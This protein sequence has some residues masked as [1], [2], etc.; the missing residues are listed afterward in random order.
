MES[1]KNVV[2]E[3]HTNPCPSADDAAGGGHDLISG[4]S[5]DVLVRILGLVG[6]A[7]EV[8]RTGALSRRWRGLWAGAPA[9]YFDVGGFMSPGD[10]ERFIAVIDDVL[11]LRARSDSGIERVE[12]SFGVYHGCGEPRLAPSCVGAAE[13]WIRYAVQH[14]LTSFFF[15]VRVT[16]K[17]W[18]DGFDKEDEDVGEDYDGDGDEEDGEE[19]KV[20]VDEEENDGGS[21][22]DNHSS[23]IDNDKPEMPAIA[24][25]ELPSSARL[26]TMRL[27]LGGAGVRLPN[28]VVFASLTDLAL[29][30]MEIAADSGHLLA[31]LLSPASCPR[32]QKLRLW[33][34]KLAAKMELLLESDVLTELSLEHMDKLTSLELRTPGLLDLVVQECDDL[35]TLTVLAPK[36]KELACASDPSL[37]AIHGGL[38]CV[39]RLK[40]D[41]CSHGYYDDGTDDASVSLLQ[42][43]SSATSLV[44]FLYIS[45]RRDL[46]VDLIKDKIP[47]LPHVTSLEIQVH[48]LCERHSTADGAASLL[49]RFSNLRYLALQLNV[50]NKKGDDDSYNVCDHLDDWSPHEIS[51]VHL[52]EAE[53]RGLTGTDCELRFLQRVLASA[54]DLQKVVVTFSARYRLEDRRDGFILA[55]L[56]AAGTWT[57]ACPDASCQPY[58]YQWRPSCT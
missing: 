21:E 27:F 57:T 46:W 1:T 38:P 54:A 30:C 23:D 7:R 55:L 49:T 43:C 52:Q 13:R 8:V 6:D 41:L 44:V 10:A 56:G 39:S 29:E 11:A 4:L 53:F 51:L 47:R 19:D 16:L 34:L 15:E 58:E 42:R 37:V 33:H 20:V 26:E 3:E 40:V 9:L 2:E 35:E 32:L 14:A 28:T 24:L 12:I 25:D 17:R 50:W 31:G 48:P 36:L 5:D 18:L 45:S 22:E